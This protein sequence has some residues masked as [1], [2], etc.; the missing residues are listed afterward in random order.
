MH[1]IRIFCDD[2]KS[3]WNRCTFII[4]IADQPPGHVKSLPDHALV[5][6]RRDET[7]G[8]YETRFGGVLTLLY[9]GRDC[10]VWLFARP[11]SPPV[12]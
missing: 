6:L 8:D 12:R 7:P 9:T 2:F 10:T 11:G 3:I 4:N 5:V 1:F